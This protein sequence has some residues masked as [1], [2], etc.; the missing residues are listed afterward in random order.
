MIDKMSDKPTSSI[1]VSCKHCGDT[2]VMIH[3]MKLYLLHCPCCWR[4]TKFYTT[5]EEA[6]DEWNKH[7]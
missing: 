6:I 5:T 3:W 1:V 7:N 4:G 2:P